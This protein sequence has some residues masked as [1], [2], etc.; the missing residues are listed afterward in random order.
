MTALTT[1]S[2]AVRNWAASN[3]K[4]SEVFIIGSWATGRATA[5]SDLDIAVL[6][7]DGHGY[8]DWFYESETWRAEL[9]MLVAPPVHL[10]RGGGSLENSVVEAAILEHGVLVYRRNKP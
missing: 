6:L 5:D 8:S 7:L 2:E 1:W 9:D 4:V 10:L 3:P